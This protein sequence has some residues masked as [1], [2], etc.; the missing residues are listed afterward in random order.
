VAS[1]LRLAAS[2]PI[3]RGA[4]TSR[5]RTA[6]PRDLVRSTLFLAEVLAVI[7]LRPLAWL[8][9]PPAREQFTFDGPRGACEGRLY[10]P[11]GGRRRAGVV[12]FLGA[13]Q[14]GPDDPRV[15]RLADGLARSG[16]VTLMCWSTAMQEGLLQPDDL[17][18]LVAAFEYL[19]ARPEVDPARVGFISFCVGAAYT[20]V[21]AAEPSIAERVAF[22]TVFGPYYSG[23]DQIR[24]MGTDRAFSEAGSRPWPVP[25]QKHADTRYQ[26][27]RML[28]DALENEAEHERVADAFTRSAP[29]PAGLSPAASAAYQL[30][31]GAP[32]E[33]SERLIDQLPPRFLARADRV[34][35]RGQLEGLRAETLVIHSTSD[36][37]IPVEESRRL[38]EALRT[39]VPTTHC[40]L[41]MFEHTDVAGATR[42]WTIAR[43]FARLASDL[44]VLLR[45]AG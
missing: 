36:E 18:M 28:F 23:R 2:L 1:Q 30:L 35:P 43:E 15:D 34:S 44:R 24:A 33:G 22:L 20:L 25:W 5:R 10:Q 12:L 11:S 6:S 19:V 31:T 45:Y 16:F 27:E 7:P 9:R 37:L 26:Y 41:S 29:E 17:D 38:V 3:A 39:R 4:D 14:A 13:G 40:E 8:T 21:A 32:F 42:V